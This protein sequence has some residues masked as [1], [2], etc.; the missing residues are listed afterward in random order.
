MRFG[1]CGFVTCSH[2]TDIWPCAG[3]RTRKFVS[4]SAK[5]KRFQW[6]YSEREKIVLYTTATILSGESGWRS[7]H[8]SRFPPLRP[9]IE[10]RGPHVGGDLSISIWLRGFFS[11]Y[12][13][14]PSS[15]TLCSEVVH[16]P[17]S[18]SQG[19]LYIL[20]VRPRWVA[21]PLYVEAVMSAS[22]SFFPSLLW[23]AM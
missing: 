9:G 20:S 19:R 6:G 7:G 14:F 10:S 17:Y 8:H 21:L 16:G 15:L 18:G 22:L 4:I 3:N 23:Q 5:K 13:G 11:G 2:K 12:S 1:S